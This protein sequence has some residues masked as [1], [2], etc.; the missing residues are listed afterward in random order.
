[1]S[2]KCIESHT[3]VVEVLNIAPRQPGW[4]GQLTHLPGLSANRVRTGNLSY[5]VRFAEQHRIEKFNDQIC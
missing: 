5:F 3:T 1:M 4:S 2:P